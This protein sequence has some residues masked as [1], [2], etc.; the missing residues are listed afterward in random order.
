MLMSRV[1]LT[2]SDDLAKEAEANGLLKPELIASL[3]KAEIRRRKIN[4]LF[5]A[6]DRLAELDEPLTEAEVQA[7]IAATRQARK[8]SKR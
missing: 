6:A 2:L 4:R 1:I 8:E 3:L 7:E 5:A